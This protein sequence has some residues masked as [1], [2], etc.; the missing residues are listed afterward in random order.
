MTPLTRRRLQNFCA[1][2]RGFWSLW[3]FL[4]LFG[5]SMFAEFIANDQPLLVRFDGHFYFPVFT[6]YT[7]TDFGGDLPIPADYRDPELGKRI[8]AGGFSG[9]A[10]G[11]V[12]LDAHLEVG[13]EL[14]LDL[15]VDL[16]PVE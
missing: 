12:V 5:L 3:L 11:D 16:R 9:H 2:K 8:A 7:E 6:A 15:E 1:N 4:L 13:L 14:S 10:G